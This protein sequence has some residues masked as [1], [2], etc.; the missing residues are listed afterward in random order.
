MHSITWG[1]RVIERSHVSAMKW[2]LRC[3]CVQQAELFYTSVSSCIL[4]EKMLC[5]SC[6]SRLSPSKHNY[7]LSYNSTFQLSFLVVFL[8]HHLASLAGSESL[9]CE[10]IIFRGHLGASWL[11][12]IDWY[13]TIQA[14]H[15]SKRKGLVQTHKNRGQHIESM[16]NTF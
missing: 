14:L 1:I 3:P 15:Q 10:T 11:W 9:A 5:S 2:N 12:L 13:D 6:P 4:P 8:R 16:A 7:C